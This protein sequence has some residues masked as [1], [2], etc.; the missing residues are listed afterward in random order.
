MLVHCPVQLYAN[1]IVRHVAIAGAFQGLGR[2]F[3]GD[4]MVKQHCIALDGERGGGEL[5]NF[6]VV[7]NQTF[8]SV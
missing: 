3:I 4:E 7:R 8:A 2:T 5:Y 1:Y 6:I